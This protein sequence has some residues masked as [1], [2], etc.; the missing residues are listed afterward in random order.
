MNSFFSKGSLV[1]FGTLSFVIL[2]SILIRVFCYDVSVRASVYPLDVEVGSPVC[3]CDST[4]DAEHV[5]WEFGNY[6]FSNE[7]KGS[8]TYNEVGEYKIRLTID[9]VKTSYFVVNVREKASYKEKRDVRIKAPSCVQQNEYVVFMADGD[10]DNWS[11]EFGETGKIDSQEKNPIHVYSKVGTYQVKLLA[12]NMKYPVTHTIN[13]LPEQGVDP[14]PTPPGD[15]FKEVLQK[16]TDRKGKFNDNYNFLLKKFLGGR[17]NTPVL[18][19]GTNQNDFYS[20]CNGLKI[21]GKQE[22]TLILEVFLEKDTKGNVRRVLVSQM[23]NDK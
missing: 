11:W 22:S 23:S 21:M 1:V 3:F 5:V 13:V 18:I 12:A 6:D 14:P 9:N 4:L 20:Y 8:Y 10:S 19:N 16:I 2:C 7:K 17:Q 15:T